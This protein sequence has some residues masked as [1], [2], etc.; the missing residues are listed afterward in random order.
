MVVCYALEL[1]H[2][3]LPGQSVDDL[4][5]EVDEGDGGRDR[6]GSKDQ[7]RANQ[8]DEEKMTRICI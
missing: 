5:A 8:F 4:D 1:E 7:D 3:E 6:R 2:L